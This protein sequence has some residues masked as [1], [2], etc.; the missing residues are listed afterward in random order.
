MLSSLR[1][2]VGYAVRSF[3]KVPGLTAAIV[4]SIGLAIAANATVFSMVNALLLKDLPVREPERLYALA[5]GNGATFSYPDY[6]DFRDQS[7]GVFEGVAAHCPFVPANLNA[8]GTPRRIWGQ[9]VSG[10]YFS[11]LGVQPALG[12]GILPREDE[13]MGR[14]A[15]VV[16][17]YGLWQRLGRDPGMV[18]K[19][20]VLSGLPYTVVGVAPAGFLGTDRIIA[21]E[22]WAPLAMYGRLSPDLL[23]DAG[24]NRGA[25]WLELAGRLKSGVGRGQ[26][27]AAVNVV[28]SRIYAD[29][30][31]NTKPV[32]MK[33]QPVGQIPE[34]HNAMVLLLSTL[35]V[36]V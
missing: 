18:G 12:R 4:V 11:I 31:T 36:V 19:T 29:H 20:I 22:F 34:V 1:Q 27:L 7:A 5:R 26:A 24:E 16:L 3:L 21:P 15:V 33:L 32:P 30:E 10:N 28:N 35:T 9:L 6:R 8:G 2:D 23:K 14:D 25:H 13:V 17:G